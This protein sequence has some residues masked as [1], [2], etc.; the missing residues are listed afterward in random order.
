MI[1]LAFAGALLFIY[2]FCKYYFLFWKYIFNYFDFAMVYV[3]TGLILFKDP[4]PEISKAESNKIFVCILFCVIYF[5]IYKFIIGRSIIISSI[6]NTFFSV[7]GG[8]FTC[9]VVL[10]IGK[11][12]FEGFPKYM[13]YML[14]VLIFSLSTTYFY[15]KRMKHYSCQA[16]DYISFIDRKFLNNYISN[17]YYV[18]EPEEEIYYTYYDPRTGYKHFYYEHEDNN[19]SNQKSYEDHS[20][21]KEKS[22]SSSDYKS[23]SY[24]EEFLKSCYILGCEPDDDF[25]TI[26]N[27]YKYLLK[28]LHPDKNNDSKSTEY[29][30]KLNNAM[31]IIKKYKN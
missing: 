8:I 9:E 19:Y 28:N 14:L 26:K 6:H 5:L 3:L 17:R 12:F 18:E 13:I 25:E 29:V 10:Y 31:D 7:L 27:Q 11:S 16:F 22:Y 2:L 24:P 30:Q 21:E 1:A 4:L 20:R 15:Y 23:N